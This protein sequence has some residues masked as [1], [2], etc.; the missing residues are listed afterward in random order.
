MGYELFITRNTGD[1]DESTENMITAQEW[2]AYISGDPELVLDQESLH[3]GPLE[4]QYY[5]W[6]GHPEGGCPGLYFYKGSIYSKYPDELM[7]LKMIAIAKELSAKVR[8]EDGEFYEDE[9]SKVK[10]LMDDGRGNMSEQWVSPP[11]AS[12]PPP[13]QP[14]PLTPKPKK[15]WWK[16]W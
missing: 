4:D 13:P 5:D 14:P 16:F 7:I 8:G 15:A 2:L 6:R 1:D 12:T 9:G 3:E 11:L 10:I